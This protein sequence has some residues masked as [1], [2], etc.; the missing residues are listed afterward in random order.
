MSSHTLPVSTTAILA[1]AREAGQLVVNMQQGGLKEIHSKST[2]VDL[3]TEADVASER[4]LSRELATLDPA[5]GFWGE[6]SNIPPDTEYYWI[7]D[8]ID[9]TVNYASGVPNYSISIALNH[10]QETLFGLVLRLPSGELFWAERGYGAHHI[11][12][13]GHEERLQVNRVDRLED[14]MVTTGFPYHR[15]EHVDNNIAEFTRLLPLCRSVRCFGS[16]A[17]DLA[18]I[19]AGITTAHWEGW[20][21]P[22]DVAAGKLLI[23]EAGGIVTTYSGAP[24]TLGSQS[25]IAS[26]GQPALHQMLVEQLQ[27]ARR[28]LPSRLFEE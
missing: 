19:A 9:G 12:P 3:V 10:L 18:W 27:S 7:V 6:E 24:Y 2:A 20:L 14:A 4:L 22:W 17:V 11:R 28:T 13:D 25:C 8:P 23:E 26:N 15:G 1:L 21:N 16:A 5:I